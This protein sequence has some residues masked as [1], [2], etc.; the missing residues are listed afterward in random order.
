MAGEAVD[1]AYNFPPSLSSAQV[2]AQMDALLEEGL[3]K[4]REMQEATRHRP[5][6]FFH[7]DLHDLEP[8]WW[9]AIWKLFKR[10][11]CLELVG[12]GNCTPYQDATRQ[13]IFS[14]LFHSSSRHRWLFFSNENVFDTE[15]DWIPNGLHLIRSLLRN[16][17]ELLVFN[18]K[19]FEAE[20]PTIRTDFL[21]EA[22]E[23]ILLH[24]EACRRCTDDI[25]D[26]LPTLETMANSQR[27]RSF[28]R[29]DHSGVQ[30]NLPS[31]DADTGSS[32][33]SFFDLDFVRSSQAGIDSAARTE[34][35]GEK[36]QVD[37][38]MPLPL[39]CASRY[40]LPR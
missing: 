33:D 10:G 20:F 29:S 6:R 9:I 37:I 11:C 35:T 16:L 30:G 40:D 38:S 1:R 32:D 14:N 39:L 5:P 34:H 22:H 3:E 27:E 28:D 23:E 36:Q 15:T 13:T 25:R 7:N 19:R 2:L 31:L 12:D 8:L 17:R 26:L 21:E 18:Y 4:L 24:F